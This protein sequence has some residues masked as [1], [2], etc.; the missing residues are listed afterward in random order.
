VVR[1]VNEDGTYQVEVGGR[2]VTT[3][4]ETDLPLAPGATVYVSKVQNGQM[5]VHGPR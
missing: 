5:V 2:V 3:T 4:P 1:A